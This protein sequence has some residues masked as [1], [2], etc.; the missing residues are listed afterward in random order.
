MKKHFK[1]KTWIDWVKAIVAIDIA[2]VGISLVLQQEMHVLANILGFLSRTIFGVLYL[3]V[4]IAILKGVFPELFAELKE[5]HD[6]EDKVSHKKH[7]SAHVG[8]MIEQGTEKVKIFVKD[9]AKEA[10]TEIEKILD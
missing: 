10:K 4:A 3:I 9:R 6:H 8:E 5:S 7:T 1:N 2:T